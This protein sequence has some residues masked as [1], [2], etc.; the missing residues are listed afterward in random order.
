MIGFVCTM[1]VR[2]T[3]EAKFYQ[4]SFSNVKILTCSLQRAA[5]MREK[6]REWII[7]HV[8]ADVD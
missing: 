1:N 3:E 6:S 7:R 8:Y 2:S 4:I 5:R